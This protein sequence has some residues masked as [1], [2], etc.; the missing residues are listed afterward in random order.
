MKIL[1]TGATG[2]IGRRVVSMLAPQHEVSALA[3]NP[4]QSITEGRVS[5]IMLDLARPLDHRVLPSQ[6]DVIIHLAQANVAFP[7]SAEEMFAVNTRSTLQLLDYGRRAGAGR[8]ILASSGDVYGFRI[9]AS[10]E[11]DA[12]APQSFYAITKLSSELLVNAYSSY[13]EPCVLRFFHPYGPG[14]SNRLIARLAQRIR[15]GES[16]RLHNNDRP[17]VSPV[18]IDDAVTAVDRAINSSYS[19]VVNI[20]GNTSISMRDLATKIGSV[21]ECEPVFEETG[22]EA[23]DLVGCD[24]L[25]KQVLGTWPM[26]GLTDGLS[27]MLKGKEDTG[28]Q[29]H[30]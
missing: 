13:I 29:A 9:G 3:R 24:E 25:M 30:V 23:G 8:F 14:Q 19:G 21:I 10:K 4:A 17:H 7:E 18:Y 1:I 12:P 16:V 6:V 22:E 15:N 27:R 26:V 2:F 28:C 20:A 11:T 5:T